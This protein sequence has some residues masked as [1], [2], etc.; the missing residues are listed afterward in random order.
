MLEYIGDTVVIK[1]ERAIQSRKEVL[2]QLANE[3]LSAFSLVDPKMHNIFLNAQEINSIGF[4][5]IFICYNNGISRLI[6]IQK[7]DVYKKGFR[8]T[9]GRHKHDVGMHK[10]SENQSKEIHKQ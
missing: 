2:W 4:S 7:Q 8:I 6:N 10:L 1:E 3:L 9:K 5:K